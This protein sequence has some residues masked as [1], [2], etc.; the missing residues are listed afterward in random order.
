MLKRRLLVLT[1]RYPYPTIGGDRVR[2]LHFC[3]ALRSEF[4]LTL[5]SLCETRQEML[6]E[7]QDGLFESIHRV[8]LPRWKSW[9]NMLLALPGEQPLQIAY[10]KS[11]QFR[12]AVQELTPQHDVVLAH[13]IRAGQY[14]VDPRIP[15]ILEMTSSVSLGYRRI[16]DASGAAP[17]KKLVY[18][19]EG[20]RLQPYEEKA[21]QKFDRVWLESHVDR[22]YLDPRSRGAIEV[23]PN[24]A[25]LDNLPYR[26]PADQGNV[27]VFIGNMASLQNQV[28]CRYFIEQILP[29]VRRQV[30]VTFRIVGNAPSA[31]RR[32]LER[33]EDVELSG[34]VERIAD[35]MAGAFCGV[36]PV[37]GVAGTQSKV[38]DYLALGLPCVSS[39]AGLGDVDAR[40]G[41]EV[42]VFR[43]AEEAAAQILMLHSNPAF[44]L[45]LA[46]AGRQLV[47]ARY[48]WETIYRSVVKSCMQTVERHPAWRMA[49]NRHRPAA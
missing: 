18:L 35:H 45:R 38:L 8:L 11:N 41:A 21:V 33:Y 37:Q 40:P 27:I 47:G 17:W 14:L 26:P 2:I 43:D 30:P 39:S 7:P 6:H 42:L 32:R 29:I 15:R 20:K 34:R 49:A 12:S 24:G 28:A 25:D 3:R 16:L 10:Y 1:P 23:I 19:V 5:L 44:R 22:S 31:I 48:D 4:R 36:C 46:W 13:L 9:L